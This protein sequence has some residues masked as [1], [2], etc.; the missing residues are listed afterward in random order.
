MSVI[1]DMP[2]PASC[3]ECPAFG[4]RA[5]RFW[6]KHKTYSDQRTTRHK[7]CPIKG[8]INDG[9]YRQVKGMR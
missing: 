5:C 6:D 3:N 2:M 7:D 8:E 9:I 1:I 4:T